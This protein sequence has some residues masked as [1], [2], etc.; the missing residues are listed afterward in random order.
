MDYIATSV[1]SDSNKPVKAELLDVN[2]KPVKR[3]GT[4]EKEKADAIVTRLMKK[5]EG[6]KEDHSLIRTTG[7]QSMRVAAIVADKLE[8]KLDDDEVPPAALPFVLSVTARAGKELLSRPAPIEQPVWS[9][10]AGL[11]EDG[12]EGMQKAIEADLAKVSAKA[13]GGVVTDMG[14]MAGIP[15]EDLEGL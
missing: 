13:N 5:H 11:S 1:V 14:A 15:E 8:K 12:P 7:I 3:A 4:V 2:N 6:F 10:V 9:K